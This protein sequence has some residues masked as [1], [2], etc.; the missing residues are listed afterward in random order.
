MRAYNEKGIRLSSLQLVTHK[1]NNKMLQEILVVFK[2]SYF[3]PHSS[4]PTKSK[5]KYSTSG[6]QFLPP[7]TLRTSKL[8]SVFLLDKFLL[9]SEFIEGNLPGD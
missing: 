5:L 4:I 9:K 7:G 1:I 3:A 8:H 2:H 6:T